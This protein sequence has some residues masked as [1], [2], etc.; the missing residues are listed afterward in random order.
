M[1][2]LSFLI[3]TLVAGLSFALGSDGLYA[4]H[5]KIDT[6]ESWGRFDILLEN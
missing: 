4:Y 2:R 5:T 3:G 1:Q 6:G